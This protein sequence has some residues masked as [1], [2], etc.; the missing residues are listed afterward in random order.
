MINIIQLLCEQRKDQHIKVVATVR[1]YALD[2][3][4]EASKRCGV[5]TE[6]ELPIMKDDEIKQFVESEIRD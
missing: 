1:D 3:V 6:I 5:Y 4:R 2:Q